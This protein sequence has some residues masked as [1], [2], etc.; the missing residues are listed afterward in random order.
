MIESLKS[1]FGNSK[2]VQ[3]GP[4]YNADKDHSSTTYMMK[5]Q[6]ANYNEGESLRQMHRSKPLSIGPTRIEDI[7]DHE[8]AMREWKNLKQRDERRII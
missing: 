8:E 7:V 1:L 6:L 2:A 4:K 5:N 3:I